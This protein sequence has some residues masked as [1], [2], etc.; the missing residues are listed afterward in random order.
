MEGPGRMH[1]HNVIAWTV[2]S[3]CLPAAVGVVSDTPAVWREIEAVLAACPVVLIKVCTLLSACE[4]VPFSPFVGGHDNGRVL[5]LAV[6]R[7]DI[8]RV[9][10]E[11]CD[12]RPVVSGKP[13]V[14]C[15]IVRFS[16]VERSCAF[17]VL[18]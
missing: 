4:G 2:A 15:S 10:A 18:N 6:T 16:F 17:T 7:P 3:S 9:V 14:V 11:I 8:Y 13:F 1:R 5:A 12:E